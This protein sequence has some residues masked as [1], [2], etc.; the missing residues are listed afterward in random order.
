MKKSWHVMTYQTKEKVWR[1]RQKAA[2]E[3]KKL[4]DL[5]KQLREE[6]QIEELR[7]VQEEAGLVPR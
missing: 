6:R 7:R 3:E 1:A 5:R 4:Q 2:E